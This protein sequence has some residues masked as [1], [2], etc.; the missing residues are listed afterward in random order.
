MGF[1]IDFHEA[2]QPRAG[3][4]LRVGLNAGVVNPESVGMVKACLM[5]SS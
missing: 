1:L 3:L 4:D 5:V 2:E